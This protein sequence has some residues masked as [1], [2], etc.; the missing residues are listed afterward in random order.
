MFAAPSAE[1]WNSLEMREIAVCGQQ[2]KRFREFV[3]E[4]LADA[5]KLEFET[6]GR[7]KKEKKKKKIW[8][9]D[10]RIGLRVSELFVIQKNETSI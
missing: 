6:S 8:D 3:L 7:I 10:S 9:I 1:I 2:T 5:S 4:H